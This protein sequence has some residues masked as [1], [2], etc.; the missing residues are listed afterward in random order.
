MRKGETANPFTLSPL[1]P[2]LHSTP[3]HLKVL[4]QTL[5]PHKVS[6]I[7]VKDYHQLIKAIKELKI[8]GAPLI[9]VAGA[10]GVA[11][12]AQKLSNLK[13]RLPQVIKEL[14]NARPTA[15]N[16]TWALNRMRKVLSLDL[17]LPALK[18]ALWEEARRIEEEEREKCEMIGRNGARLLK[19]RSKVL[20][21]CNTG[22]LA[23]P[24]IGTA[25]GIIYKA[26]ERG[27]EIT[28]FVC[29]TRPLL[30]GARLTAWELNRNG[31]RVIL[32]TDGMVATI[33]PEID[34]VLTGAD[35]IARNFDFANKIGTLNLAI[36]AHYYKKP[37]Y[38]VAPTSTIDHSIKD[39]KGIII[40]E[41]DGEEVLTCFGKA[42][43]PK[44]IGVKN[45]AFDITPRKLITGLI[46]EK[47]I[48]YLQRQR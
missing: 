42:I 13:K 26:K 4:D 12:E 21:I 5:L 23:T 28:V 25:L 11:L 17:S 32:I 10:Y 30:Q 35:R 31:I 43:A 44:G 20:T 2:F 8:R 9:G 16:L 39:G 22:I 33:M 14:A 7:K 27:K 48:I 47:G 40:E 18:K 36:C 41:R 34:I 38:C 3:P 45:P 24:G 19:D 46:T 1:L 6:Y 29:E 15:V 37:F